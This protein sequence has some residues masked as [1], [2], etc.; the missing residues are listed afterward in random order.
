ME[1]TAKKFFSFGEAEK[2]NRDFY[3]SLPATNVFAFWWSS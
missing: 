1:K 2:A 3:K